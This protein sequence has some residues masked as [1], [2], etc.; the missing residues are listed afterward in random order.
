MRIVALALLLISACGGAGEP[1][2]RELPPADPRAAQKYLQASKL[3]AGPKTT[4]ERRAAALL[5]EALTIDPNLWEAHYNLGV[6]HR[7]RGELKQA[8]KEF[9]AAHEIQPGAAAPLLALAA[10]HYAMGDA[11]E[12]AEI[13]SR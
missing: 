2:V 6:L 11:G 1:E 12:A 3:L 13:L 4:D 5:Q 9:A 10:V 8:L 7:R